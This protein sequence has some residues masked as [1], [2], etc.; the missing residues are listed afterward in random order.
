MEI[1]LLFNNASETVVSRFA[2][3]KIERA[4][5]VAIAAD[6]NLFRRRLE[7]L[8]HILQLHKPHY[9]FRRKSTF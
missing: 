9:N 6:E 8:K 4:N 5:R 1:Y 3:E 2:K 7:I